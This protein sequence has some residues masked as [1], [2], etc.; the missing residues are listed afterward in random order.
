MDR[1]GL[2]GG[3]IAA[4]AAAAFAVISRPAPAMAT[5]E[6]TAVE[7]WPTWVAFGDRWAQL[8]DQNGQPTIGWTGRFNDDGEFEWDELGTFL[9]GY[10]APDE[11]A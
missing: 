4:M 1:R 10:V 8:V 9:P 3:G 2:L 11:T 5:V 7:T 6:V